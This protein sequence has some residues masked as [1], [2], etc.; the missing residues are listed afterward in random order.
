MPKRVYDAT[1]ET[2]QLGSVLV[3]ALFEA[4]TTVY[5][6]KTARYVRLATNGTGELP[7]GEIPADLQSV[8]AEEASA[9]AGQFLAICI[10]AIDYCPPV[11]LTLGEYL[12]ALITADHDLV[13]DDPWGYRE[14]L[15]D[16]FWRREIYPQGVESLSE[17]ALLWRPTIRR[18]PVFD[19]LTFAALRFEGDPARPA[20]V[21]E[22]QRQAC[23]LGDVVTQPEYMPEFG[24]APPD[25]PDLR[26]DSVEP[27][28]VESIRSTRRVGP[29]GQIV[30]DLVAEVTQRRTVRRTDGSPEFDCYGGSTVILGPDGRVRYVI[31]KSVLAPERCAR[32][33]EFIRGS[34]RDLWTERRISDD[35]AGRVTLVPQPQLFKRLHLAASERRPDLVSS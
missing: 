14:A 34:G 33:R 7:P 5:Q 9:L 31:S 21:D 25:H 24:L 15:I 29:D 19:Q 20:G 17:D 3:A 6:R 18:I 11:D 1:A 26:G 12:R 13:P 32:Q 28:Y 23:A 8:L 22:L 27:P 30:F 2:H 16:A 10:R 35:D 4:F